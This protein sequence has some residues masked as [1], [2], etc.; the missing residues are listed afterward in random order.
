MF[1]FGVREV[2]SDL[3]ARIVL[4]LREKKEMGNDVSERHCSPLGKIYTKA[5]CSASNI[6][7]IFLRRESDG[8]IVLFEFPDQ[9][10]KSAIVSDATILI[11][12]PLE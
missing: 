6:F 3:A 8:L 4:R 11:G 5:I 7:P 10:T 1:I 12:T 9:I 2:G